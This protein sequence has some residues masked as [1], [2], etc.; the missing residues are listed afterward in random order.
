MT[1]RKE[2]KILVVTAHTFPYTF[3]GG[4]NAYNWVQF[5]NSIGKNAK[6]LSYSSGGLRIVD[7]R[8][9]N[10]IKVGWF[11]KNFFTKVVSLLWIAPICFYLGLTHGTIYVIGVHFIGA[12]CVLLGAK[13]GRA[14]T[15][16]QSTLLG[17]DDPETIIK[18]KGIKSL[19]PKTILNSSQLFHAINPSFINFSPEIDSKLPKRHITAVQGLNIKEFYAN[20]N[21]EKSERHTLAL[22]SVGFLTKRKGHAEVFQK[23]ANCSIPF[24]FTIATNTQLPRRHKGEITRNEMDALI[25]LGKQHLGNRLTFAFAPQE[26]PQI[27]ANADVLILNSYAEGTPNVILE[28]MACGVIPIVRELPGYRDFI[29]H[30]KKTGFL[31]SEIEEI[32]SILLELYENPQLIRTISEEAANYAKENFSFQKVWEKIEKGLANG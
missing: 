7:R 30:H 25:E 27:Y 3:G 8:L 16:Y 22:L 13:V 5:F 15:I 23:L 12:P 26:M 11:N 32:D 28:A 4:L 1:K 10:S 20:R 29:I 31:Y 9:N 17:D 6:I 18:S 24:N 2:N 19:L 14:R 21:E